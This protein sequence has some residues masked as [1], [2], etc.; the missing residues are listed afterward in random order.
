MG[1]GAL[2]AARL[3]PHRRS[4]KAILY[5]PVVG[6]LG[7][8]CPESGNDLWRS[9]FHGYLADHGGASPREPAAPPTLPPA[10][11]PPPSARATAGWGGV[12]GG[13]HARTRSLHRG[14]A[15]SW[16]SDRAQSSRPHSRW[17]SSRA[18]ARRRAG[19]R[20]CASPMRRLAFSV[21][22]TPRPPRHSCH[23]PCSMRHA[24][25]HTS[26][27]ESQKTDGRA[28]RGPLRARTSPA[29]HASPLPADRPSRT[30]AAARP[31]ASSGGP[32]RSGS[33]DAAAQPAGSQIGRQ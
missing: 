8:R 19:V 16:I 4:R 18:L 11:P 24:L 32:P 28:P 13:R 6:S 29:A 31:E 7:S 23:G 21:V 33:G 22:R 27:Q 9:H 12:V 25:T 30:R 1:H 14:R 5:T 10:P 20:R 17:P 3:P 2:A 15:G 26:M